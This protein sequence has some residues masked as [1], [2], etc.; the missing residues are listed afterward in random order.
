MLTR[1]LILNHT[2][3]D[4]C[5]L[6]RYHP[7]LWASIQRIYTKLVV[8]N[9]LRDQIFHRNTID[10]RGSIRKVPNF[11]MWA[12]SLDKLRRS[13]DKDAC[14]I[15]KSWNNMA[16]RRQQSLAGPEAEALKTMLEMMPQ[17]VFTEVVVP[18]VSEMG[19]EKSPWSDDAFSNKRIY[20]GATPVGR[21]SSAA[22]RARLKVTD[23]SLR[24]MLKCQV[25]K[26][27]KLSQTFSPG[28]THKGQHGR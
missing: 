25:D 12:L 10:A 19:W 8:W 6:E 16:S 26:H 7:K 3:Q 11:I 17:E 21:S 23:P 2:P 18:A 9:S 4:G 1:L 13:G 15:I 22:W 20:P 5:S 24:I 28:E 27:K 14:A